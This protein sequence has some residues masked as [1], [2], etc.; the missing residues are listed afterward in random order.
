MC[1][2]L[3]RFFF[4]LFFCFFFFK[5]SNNIHDVSAIL[6]AKSRYIIY[7]WNHVRAACRLFS[8]FT[9]GIIM[10]LWWIFFGNIHIIYTFIRI[11][12]KKSETK[13]RWVYLLPNWIRKSNESSAM[14]CL[15]SKRGRFIFWAELI[16]F[17]RKKKQTKKI[18]SSIKVIVCVAIVI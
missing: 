11:W 5:F 6:V 18:N 3:S 15:L 7:R 12:K 10:Y 8:C 4:F 16:Q 9:H 2:L 14:Y 17:S 1:L 13:C